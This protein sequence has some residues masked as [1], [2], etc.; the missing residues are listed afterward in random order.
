MQ[1]M[2]SLFFFAAKYNIMLIKRHIPRVENGAADA[3]S[4]WNRVILYNRWRRQRIIPH[5]STPIHLGL[6]RALIHQRLN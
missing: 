3:L 2:W 5:P 1:L 4:R 6:V